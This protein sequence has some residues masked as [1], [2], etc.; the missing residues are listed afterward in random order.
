MQGFYRIPDS[1]GKKLLSDLLSK[2][3]VKKRVNDE[4]KSEDS[5]ITIKIV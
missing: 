1:D 2:F 3:R 4:V 5:K